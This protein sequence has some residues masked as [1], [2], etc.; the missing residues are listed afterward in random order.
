MQHFHS[1][2][3][4]DHLYSWTPPYWDLVR[5]MIGFQLYDLFCTII[6]KDLRKLEHIAHHCLTL[7]TGL[8]GVSG[9]YLL[10]QGPFFFGITEVLSRPRTWCTATPCTF[11]WVHC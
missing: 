10:H 4:L 2:S 5:F 7:V 9:P 3:Y 1:H 6:V 8:C 11:H